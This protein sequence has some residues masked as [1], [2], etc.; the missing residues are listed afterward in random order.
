MANFK[1]RRPR[2]LAH[3]PA[4][5]LGTPSRHNIVFHS[6]PRRRLDSKLARSIRSGID[7]DATLWPL[8]KRPHKY[9]W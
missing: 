6:R 2:T 1:R 7:P 8:S 4:R 3:T 9:Y 5:W